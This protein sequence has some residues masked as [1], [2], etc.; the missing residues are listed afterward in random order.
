MPDFTQ[1]L[2]QP[3]GKAKRPPSL[4]G[5]DYP[6]VITGFEHGESRQKKTPYVQFNTKLTGWPVDADPQEDEDGKVIDI[7]KKTFNTKFYLTEDSLFRLDGFLR[8]LGIEL[9]GKTYLEVLPETTG[10]NVLVEI[11]QEPH[12][13]TGDLLNYANNLKAEK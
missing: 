6:G 9:D 1:L 7:S 5:G 12:A 11:V 10:M 8:D 2:R 4:V 3:A 13:E